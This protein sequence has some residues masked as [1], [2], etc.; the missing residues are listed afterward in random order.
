MVQ[1]A[2]SIFITSDAFRYGSFSA[3]E[4][5]RIFHSA[6]FFAI[7]SALRASTNM[8]GSVGKISEIIFVTDGL[9]V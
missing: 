8:S 3:I 9:R 2:V 1:N 7:F 6:F 4:L 5:G